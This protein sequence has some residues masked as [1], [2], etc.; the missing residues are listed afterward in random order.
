MSDPLFSVV[1]NNYNYG[2]YLPEAVASALAQTVDREVVIVDDGSTDDSD[3]VL[4]EAEGKGCTVVRK[5]NGGQASAFNAGFARARGRWICFLDADDVLRSEALSSVEAVL[6]P[7]LAKIHFPL[8]VFCDDKGPTG[9]LIEGRGLS[10]GDVACQI[11]ATGRHSWPPTSGNVFARDFLRA[12]LPMN[13]AEYRISADLYLNSNAPFFGEIAAIDKPLARYRRHGANRYSTDRRSS[14]ARIAEAVLAV[15]AADIL[16]QRL[17]E[18]GRSYSPDLFYR[19]QLAAARLIV[20]RFAEGPKEKD[21]THEVLRRFARSP[22][23]QGASL[24]RRVLWGLFVAL[25]AYG[26]SGMLWKIAD[27]REWLANVRARGLFTL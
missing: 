20:R 25:H 2:R 16:E 13:E 9:E 7:G 24:G 4:R 23:T 3:K 17:T 15:K 8:E 11:A 27:A 26:P 5:P 22:E 6:R 12:V 10:R 1:I 14:K 19:R 21:K 18:R